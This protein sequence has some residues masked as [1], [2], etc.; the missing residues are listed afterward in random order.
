MMSKIFDQ[1]ESSIPESRVAI[2]F[3]YD[4]VFDHVLVSELFAVI[5]GLIQLQPSDLAT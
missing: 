2:W 4:I 1:S 3:I 5:R